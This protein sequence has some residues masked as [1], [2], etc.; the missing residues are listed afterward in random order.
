M[1]SGKEACL[2]PWLFV[3]K[4]YSFLNSAAEYEQTSKLLRINTST[5]KVPSYEREKLKDPLAILGSHAAGKHEFLHSCFGIDG[6][7]N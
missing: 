4:V 3:V 7:D 5:S 6:D 2:F 1:P